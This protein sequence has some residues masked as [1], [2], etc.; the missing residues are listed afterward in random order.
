MAPTRTAPSLHRPAGRGPTEGGSQ[1]DRRLDVALFVSALQLYT[2]CVLL[3]ALDFAARTWRMQLF[4][5]AL[6][7]SIP[8]HE[9]LLQSFVAEAASVL[10]PMRI[11]GDPARVWAMRQGGLSI[12]AGVVCIAIE[13]LA[14]AAILLVVTVALLLT[15]GRS[16]WATVGPQ[17]V[18][19]LSDAGPWL[20]AIV[21]ASVVSW[22]IARRVA[23]ESRTML[24]REVRSVR[25]YARVMPAWAYAAAVPLTL[26]NI[27][28]RVAVLPLLVSTLPS[29]P[30]LLATIVGSYALLYGQLLTPTPAGA[31]A[32]ELLFL[33]GGAGELGA[34]E[35]RLLF[36]WRLFTAGI[37]LVIGVAAAVLH[38]GFN[39]F[40]RP[41]LAR[42]MRPRARHAEQMAA[43][44]PPPRD[45]DDVA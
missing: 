31:G 34:A 3:V 22:L 45:E 40:G 9:V 20:L 4:L 23:P 7:R 5:R 13:T 44:T 10:T 30:P 26:V 19:S 27:A 8:F 2:I 28:A 36:L 12:T 32:V 38:Y 43:G 15:I 18:E 39:V 1:Q 17:L 41:F 35:G 29:P 11:G 14:M 24:R 16:W 21:V 33:G 25:R 6:G 37:P 42:R